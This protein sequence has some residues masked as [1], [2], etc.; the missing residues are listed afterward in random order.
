MNMKRKKTSWQPFT[1]GIVLLMLVISG[2]MY[3]DHDRVQYPSGALTAEELRADYMAYHC[4]PGS[5]K[6]LTLPD[7]T[8]VTL[9]SQTTLYVP[10]NYSTDKHTLIL[11]GEAFFEVP[12]GEVLPFT[13]KT[14]KLIITGFNGAMRVRSA[15]SQ[16]GATVHVLK[17]QFTVS[18]AYHSPTDNQPEILNAGNEVLFN[19]DIDLMEKETY[20]VA[21]LEEWKT[22]KLVLDSVPLLAAVRKIEEWYGVEL[23]LPNDAGDL[24]QVINGSF[25]NLPLQDVL[26]ALKQTTGHRFRMK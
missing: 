19:K 7:D 3:Y 15:E 13:I 14:D 10:K 16:A 25:D 8:R 22:G 11:N 18:K 23:S 9:N 17:G 20:D 21:L 1:A 5:R 24:N 4:Q 6:V 26:T 12:E 2:F